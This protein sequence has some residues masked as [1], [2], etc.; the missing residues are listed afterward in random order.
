MGIPIPGSKILYWN[1]ALS[2]ICFQYLYHLDSIGIPI[3][4]KMVLQMSYDYNRNAYTWKH[5]LLLKQLRTANTQNTPY[6]LNF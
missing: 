1:R 3:E 4:D 2:C 5:D 6:T